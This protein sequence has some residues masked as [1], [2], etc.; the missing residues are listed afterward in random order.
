MTKEQLSQL[1]KTLWAI[2]DDLR[3]AMN[4]DDF[5]DY[6]LSFLFLR[7][8]SDNFEA[9]A[10]KELGPDYPKLDADDRRPPLVVWYSDNAGDVPAF[11]KQMRRTRVRQIEA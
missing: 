9:A 6:M 1:G 5:R 3:G 4:A 2:A 8:L 7:Y 10:K 11:E